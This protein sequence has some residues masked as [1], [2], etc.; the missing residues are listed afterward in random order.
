M[1]LDIATKPGGVDFSYCEK[2]NIKAKRCPGLPAK[3][4]P[5]TSAEVLAEEA[6]RDE[7]SG[8]RR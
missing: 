5:K 6:R 2:N 8:A 1:I 4:S 3:Y 7:K